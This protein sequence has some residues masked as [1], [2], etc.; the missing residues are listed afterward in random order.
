[1]TSGAASALT[2]FRLKFENDQI[3]RQFVHIL[4][5]ADATALPFIVADGRVSCVCLKVMFLQEK[6]KAVMHEPKKF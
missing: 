2:L 3:Q 5:G 1:M 4:A 6:E